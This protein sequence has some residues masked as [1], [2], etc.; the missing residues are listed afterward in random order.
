MSDREEIEKVRQEIMRFRELLTLMK[1][2]QQRGEQSYERLFSRFPAE[3]TA[4]VKEKDL[5]WK[6]A[7]TMTPADLDALARMAG[8]M[9]FHA[10]ELEQNFEALQGTILAG[11]D[12]E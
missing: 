6:L 8:E 12:G 10:R 7:E 4:G 5:Q 1:G 3:E 2:Y 11:M 9:R